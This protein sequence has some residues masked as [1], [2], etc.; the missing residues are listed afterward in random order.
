M[1]KSL[2]PRKVK[3]TREEVREQLVSRLELYDRRMIEVMDYVTNNDINGIGSNAE[4]LTEID[5]PYYNLAQVMHQK[6]SFRAKNF[7]A[8]CERFNVDPRFLFMKD[9]LT[10][11]VQDREITAIQQLRAAVNRIEMEAKK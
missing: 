9:H 8:V 6:Q 5:F 10:M 3:L 11:F 4:F 2:M 1:V 7:A